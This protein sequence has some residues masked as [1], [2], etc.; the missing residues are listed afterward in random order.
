M[1]I[2]HRLSLSQ[3]F[4]VL[5]LIA[6]L[7]VA[8]PTVLQVR[9][10]LDAIAVAKREAQG[11][12]PAIAL[13]SMVRLVQRHRGAAAAALAGD[14]TMLGKVPA[15]AASAAGAAS[16]LDAAFASAGAAA[17]LVSRWQELRSQWQSLAG[18]VGDGRIASADST[19][20]HTRLIAQLTLLS[21]QLLDEYGLSLDPQA[22]TYMLIMATLN[23]APAMIEQMGRLRAQGAGALGSKQLTPE[24]RSAL[25]MVHGNTSA[26]YA[27]SKRFLGKATG[28]NPALGTALAAP[29][30]AL[31]TH[32]QQSL[33][34]AEQQVIKAPELTLP[35]AEYFETLTATIEAAYDFNTLALTRLTA[36]LDRRAADLRNAILLELGLLVAA[37]VAAVAL[38]LAF[39]RSIT[40]PVQEALTVAQAVAGGDL[41]VPVPVRGNNE[42]GRLMS[43][44]AAMQTK[45]AEIVGA[46]SSGAQ[47]V[48]TAAREIAAGNDDLSQ[49]TQSQ[50][51]SLEETAA[52]ME[53]MTASVRHN[54]EHASQASQL[55]RGALSH[56]ESG[57]EVVAHTVTAMAA[58]NDSSRKIV[59]II[60]VIDEIA[61]QTNLLA[62]NAAV[63]A[64]RAGEQGRGFAVV[65]S[66]VRNLA[67]RS[68]GAAKEIKGLINDSVAK[69]QAGKDLVDRSGATLTQIVEAVRKVTDIVGEIAAANAEQA[70]GIDQV[71][72]TVMSMDEMTQQNAALVEE[73]AAASRAAQDQAEG[74][75]R[76]MAFFRVER[77]AE[78]SPAAMST[79]STVK[80]PHAAT[81][82]VSAKPIARKPPAAN[83]NGAAPASPTAHRAAAAGGDNWTEF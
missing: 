60:G 8:I 79:K 69:A 75:A 12:R 38:A 59:D 53:E 36:E 47:S 18:T 24:A 80:A 23:Y 3:K 83:S 72:R 62:L 4:A 26:R 16:D 31:D 50:A 48:S 43:A 64:A 57:G 37:L 6:L 13:Q 34:L 56:A 29:A 20:Q 65:A 55:A 54:A 44:L 2:L 49:R 76:Q 41:T 1:S 17:G 22:D 25:V 5:G 68:A 45:L 30:A 21:E 42:I 40:V 15:I 78:I 82:K 63:E 67:Q 14:A 52:S 58:I 33:D 39:V 35:A 51:S 27:D 10:S 70:A 71:N 61:F 66:E 32:I 28:Y 73:A 19:H 77:T 11:T 46:V 9:Q 7:M 81:S 74:L